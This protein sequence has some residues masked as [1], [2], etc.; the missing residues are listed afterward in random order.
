VRQC[1]AW[2]GGCAAQGKRGLALHRRAWDWQS[3]GRSLSAHTPPCSCRT[4]G[5]QYS[6]GVWRLE[7]LQIPFSSSAALGSRSLHANVCVPAAS[8]LS[9]RAPSLPWHSPVLARAAR[10]PTPACSKPGRWSQTYPGSICCCRSCSFR[11]RCYTQSEA[12]HHLLGEGV[13]LTA[14]RGVIAWLH[15]C[16]SGMLSLLSCLQNSTPALPDTHT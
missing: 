6:L 16:A 1:D 10:C 8:L 2:A 12:P 11:R 9:I 7:S 15:G 4:S 3:M 5:F 13:M 14:S